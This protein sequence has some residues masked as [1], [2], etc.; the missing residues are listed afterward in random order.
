MS[1]LPDSR[2]NTDE[3]LTSYE[4][5][6][7]YNN[8]YELGS[9]KGDPHKNAHHLVT[10][11]WTVEVTGECEKPGKF[12]IEDFV[13]PHQL[14][15]RIYRLRCVEAWSMVIPWVG[16]EVS[17]LLKRVQPTSRARYVAFESIMDPENLPGQRGRGFLG[18][19]DWPYREG[20]RIDEAMNPLA[21]FAVGLYGKPAAEPERRAVAP[22]RA[23]EVRLQEQ[24]VH[25]QGRAGRA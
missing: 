19:L 18:T 14:E 8:F 20:L 1:D 16:F 13:K 4:S 7:T 15:D 21:I 25:R 5:V 2:Y 6:T 3:K 9:G 11:P 23:V 10:E 12:S 17:A 24:Q 22:G